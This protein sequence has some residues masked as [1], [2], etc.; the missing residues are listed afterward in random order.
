MPLL[1]YN[2]F[3]EMDIVSREMDKLFKNVY[4]ENEKKEMPRRDFIPQVDIT[5]DK[6]AIELEFELPGV[7][8][9]DVKISINEQ[10]V[11]LVQGDKKF[12]ANVAKTCCRNERSYGKFFRSFQLPEQID[13][14]KIE[15]TFNNG[16]L[17][18][19]IAK[20]APVE[21]ET[22]EIEVQ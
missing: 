10:N 14:G 3:W 5:E 16:V 21:P 2:P 22:K 19:R 4:A 11:L 7:E 9:S 8:K 18:I 12:P 17:Q 20:M 6:Q 15:A 1:K 13:P